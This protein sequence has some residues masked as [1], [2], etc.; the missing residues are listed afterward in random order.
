MYAV[1]YTSGS[2]E[3]FEELVRGQFWLGDGIP[4]LACL[5]GEW[6]ATTQMSTRRF[7]QNLP[8]AENVRQEV[9]CRMCERVS[10]YPGRAE[11][12]QKCSAGCRDRR[13]RSISRNQSQKS[14]S[15]NRK[16]HQQSLHNPYDNYHRTGPI[17][18]GNHISNPRPVVLGRSWCVAV[19]VATLRRVVGIRGEYDVDVWDR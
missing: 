8:P 6:W 1:L 9:S 10:T 13:I 2:A 18:L 14:K 12:T 5:H 7:T 16:P 19:C 15:T 4:H 3:P 17:D 11:P